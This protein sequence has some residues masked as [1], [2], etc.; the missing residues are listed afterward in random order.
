MAQMAQVEQMAQMEQMAQVEQVE[1]G[2]AEHPPQA[3]QEAVVVG[4]RIVDPVGIGEERA[5]DRG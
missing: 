2:L 1:R 3:P 4:P 5:H